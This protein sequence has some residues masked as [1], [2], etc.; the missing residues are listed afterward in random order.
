METVL[1][2]IDKAQFFKAGYL[3]IPQLIPA[4]MLQL[5]RNL[6]DHV[7]HQY[8]SSRDMVYQE[9][10]GK[11]LVSNIDNICNQGAHECLALLD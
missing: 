9:N 6:F 7:I 8:A 11:V 4:P 2:E 3:K 5:L 1:S 10:G